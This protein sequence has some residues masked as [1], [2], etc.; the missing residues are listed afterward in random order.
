M[1]GRG[2]NTDENRRRD[3]SHPS[4]GHFQTKVYSAPHLNRE[5]IVERK[6]LTPLRIILKWERKI[7]HCQG[8]RAFVL[9]L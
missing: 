8:G 6:G 9:L 1:K 5:D 3:G 4:I 2:V 7:I